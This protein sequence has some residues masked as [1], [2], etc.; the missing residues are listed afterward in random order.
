MIVFHV[1]VVKRLL[2][3]RKTEYFNKY[4]VIILNRIYLFSLEESIVLFQ[5]CFKKIKVILNGN[6]IKAN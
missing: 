4:E 2:F 3:D 6:Q 1:S 5:I